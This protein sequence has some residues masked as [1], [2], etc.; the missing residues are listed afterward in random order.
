VNFRPPSKFTGKSPV[1]FRPPSILTHGQAVNFRT[2]SKSTH[3]STWILMAELV[4][5]SER[6]MLTALQKFWTVV[7]PE[8]NHPPGG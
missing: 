1:N 4:G 5:E 3:Y 2:P 8:I 6:G 7:A